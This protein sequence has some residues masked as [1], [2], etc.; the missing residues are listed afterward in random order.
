VARDFFEAAIDWWHRVTLPRV[1]HDQAQPIDDDTFTPSSS[2]GCL[3][4]GAWTG[5][6]G[7]QA[8]D[9]FDFD[10]RPPDC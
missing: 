2:S 4:A 6:E 8:E 1:R 5:G 3:P 10:P 7:T 9:S